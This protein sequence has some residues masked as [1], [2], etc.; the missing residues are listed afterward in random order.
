M[1]GKE[2]LNQP[3]TE[4]N[5]TEAPF[6]NG[7]REALKTLATIPVLGAMA[8]GVYQKKKKEHN[9]KLAGNIFNF[10]DAPTVMDRQPDGK[11]IRLGI[12]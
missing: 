2:E 3:N 4:E 10:E 6:S 9:N 7:R 12:I 5:Q 1:S 8:Y 11:T